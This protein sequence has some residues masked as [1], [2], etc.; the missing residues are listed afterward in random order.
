[1]W[2][3]DVYILMDQQRCQTSLLRGLAFLR[4]ELGNLPLHALIISGFQ[5]RTIPKEEENLHP[6]EERGQ[7]ERLDQVVEQRRGP[8]FKG[9]MPNKLCYPCYGMDSTSP[10]VDRCAVSV[11]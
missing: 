7:K 11:Q 1:M 4:L 10:I 8:A 6:H 3:F 9:S 2:A 5:L